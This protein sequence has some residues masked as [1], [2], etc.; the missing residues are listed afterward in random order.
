MTNHPVTKPKP[1][2]YPTD[3]KT[4]KTLKLRLS[5]KELI[6]MPRGRGYHGTVTDTLTSKKYKVYGKSCGCAGCWCDA[7]AQ[8]VK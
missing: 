5:Q 8:E 1:N 6:G 4:G 3:K 2:F 7:F